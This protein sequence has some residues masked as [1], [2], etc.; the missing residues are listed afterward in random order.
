MLLNL[1][2]ETLNHIIA[3]L[4]GEERA[5]QS[6]S[7][8]DRRLTEECRIYLF[9]SVRIGN[10]TKLRRWCDAISP[11]KGG[12]SRYV[13]FLDMKG[14]S[15]FIPA[16]LRDHKHHLRSFS[17]LEHLDIRPLDLTKFPGQEMARFFGHFSTVRSLCAQIIGSPWA[18]INFLA[19]FPLLETTVITSSHIWGTEV[20]L[21]P[22][23]HVYRG[24]LVLRICKIDGRDDLLSSFTRPT[25]SYRRLGLGLVMVHDFSPLERFFEACGGS[26]ESIQFIN[27]LIR[28]FP[29]PPLPAPY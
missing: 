19:L 14:E 4:H 6:L 9:S 21:N 25:T 16:S 22:P 13:R 10:A 24:D 18:I 29:V 2:Q 12:L 17:Q 28:E 27:L 23:D 1:P 7:L 11:G 5:L 26:L 8:V 20:D 15:S 3:H